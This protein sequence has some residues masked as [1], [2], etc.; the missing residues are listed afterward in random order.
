M[1]PPLWHALPRPLPHTLPSKSWHDPSSESGLR[2]QAASPAGGRSLSDFTLNVIESFFFFFKQRYKFLIWLFPLHVH[3]AYVLSTCFSKTSYGLVLIFLLQNDQHLTL[4]MNNSLCK[5]R[6]F[7]GSW[8]GRR[9]AL[10]SPALC[11]SAC[12]NP[13]VR[14]AHSRTQPW[15][16]GSGC[17]PGVFRD[18]RVKVMLLFI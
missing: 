10:C 2:S 15:P 12:R 16:E 11:V 13:V 6:S 4:L 9:Q 18:G 17:H 1:V 14:A 8:E 7:L 3:S 5:P